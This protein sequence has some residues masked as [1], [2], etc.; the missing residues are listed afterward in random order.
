MNKLTKIFGALGLVTLAA[1]A[2]AE[3]DEV[4][5]GSGAQSVK[6]VTEEDRDAYLASAKIW[7]EAEWNEMASKDLLRGP[8]GEDS[9]QPTRNAD[10]SMTLQHITCEFVEPSRVKELGG[11]SPKFQCGACTTGKGCNVDKTLKVKYGA[12]ADANGEIYAEVMATR[13]F[14]AAGFKTDDVYPVRVTCLNCPPPEK[15]WEVYEKFKPGQAPRA[16]GFGR[17]THEYPWALIERKNEGKKIEESDWPEDKDGQGFSFDEVESLRAKSPGRG[18]P[19][20]EWNAFKLLASFIQHSDNKAANQR[21]ICAPGAVNDQ[22]QCTSSYLMMQDTGATFGGG[23]QI[24]GSTNSN[25]K[26]RFDNWSEKDIWR[27]RRACKAALFS[28]FYSDPVVSE[29]GRQLL[30]KILAKITDEQL[31]DIFTASRIVERGETIKVDGVR[32]AV[33]V[34]DWVSLFKAKRAELASQPCGR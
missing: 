22:K 27:D 29:D 11:K 1:C 34:E 19:N 17:G 21:V 8:G 7:D 6:N 33:M 5:S 20:A 23:G 16:D 31:R 18:A 26:A 25:S 32:R 15:A 13:L 10:G 12:T 14:W 2:A 9:F 30:G 3:A 24:F 4:E 28:F